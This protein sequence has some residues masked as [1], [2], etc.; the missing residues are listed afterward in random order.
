VQKK[1]V[2]DLLHLRDP[3]GISLPAHDGDRGLGHSFSFPLRSVE[4]SY[5]L[6]SGRIVVANDNNYPFDAGRHD[7]RPDANEWIIVQ[8]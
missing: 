6:T 7:G 2:V 3:K 5:P 1:E 8:S 4:S